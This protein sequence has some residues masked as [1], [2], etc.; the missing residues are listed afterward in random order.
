MLYGDSTSPGTS[1]DYVDDADSLSEPRVDPENGECNA[2][3]VRLAAPPVIPSLSRNLALGRGS[4]RAGLALGTHRRRPPRVASWTC[5]RDSSPSAQAGR[6]IDRQASQDTDPH[7]TPTAVRRTV[8][9][10]NLRTQ[11]RRPR[12]TDRRIALAAVRDTTR[13]TPD[14]TPSETALGTEDQGLPETMSET[15]PQPIP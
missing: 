6:Q 1:P 10:T 11:W 3:P 4:L 9:D 15:I 5:P 7:A 8:P 2:R 14:R 13:R 12:G